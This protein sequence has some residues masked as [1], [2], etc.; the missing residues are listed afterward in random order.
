[1]LVVWKVNEMKEQDPVFVKKIKPLRRCT[2]LSISYIIVIIT[3]S[4]FVACYSF[5][6]VLQA[7]LHLILTVYG[8]LT[9]FQLLQNIRL[10]DF[11]RLFDLN[12]PVFQPFSM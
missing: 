11:R 6:V 12:D 3:A 1:M 2:I 10:N 8:V 4:V 5:K 9:A 7:S